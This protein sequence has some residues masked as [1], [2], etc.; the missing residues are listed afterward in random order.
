MRKFILV[1]A[2]LFTLFV[3]NTAI[4]AQQTDDEF[5]LMQR[6]QMVAEIKE[7]RA[8]NSAK[9]V[10]IAEKDKIIEVYKQLD[11][12]QEARIADLKES[13]KFRTEANNIDLKIESMYKSQIADYKAEN[14]RL[15]EDNEK[16]RKSRDRR[17]LIFG[18]IGIVA[19][20]FIW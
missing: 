3:G 10:I 13:I 8:K 1:A 9:D 12:K 4:Q 6:A 7:L 16:L 11:L 14:T 15:R 18:A 17:S 19:G 2:F 5:D 20:K